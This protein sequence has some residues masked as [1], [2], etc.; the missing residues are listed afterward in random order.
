MARDYGRL[1]ALEAFQPCAEPAEQPGVGRA[2]R[3]ASFATGGV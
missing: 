3:L 1:R 2:R